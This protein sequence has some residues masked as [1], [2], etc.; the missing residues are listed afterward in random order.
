LNEALPL[1]GISQLLQPGY[2]NRYAALALSFEA[3]ELGYWQV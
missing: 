2:Y 1:T 3:L